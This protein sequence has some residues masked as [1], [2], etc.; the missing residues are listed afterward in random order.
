MEHI[1]SQET[2]R[3]QE[4]HAG[5]VL[6]APSIRGFEVGAIADALAR[7]AKQFPKGVGGD[8]VLHL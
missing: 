8:D 2:I 6:C 5:I 1:V 4:P 3:R 7:L